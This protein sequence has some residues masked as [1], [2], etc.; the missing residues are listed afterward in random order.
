MRKL[1]SFFALALSIAGSLSAQQTTEYP[2]DQLKPAFH[3]ARRAAF[4]EK[5]GANTVG[6]FF[7]AQV[8]NRTN[9]VDF[10]YSQNK[11]FFYFTG[12]E[13]PNAVLFI[14]KDPQTILGKTG[15]EFLF[16][17]PRNPAMELWTGK[18]MGEQRAPQLLGIENVFNHTQFNA[19]ILPIANLDSVYS[20]Y[21]T[22]DILSRI[23]RNPDPLSKMTDIVDSLIT[24]SGKKL[25][26]NTAML[27]R[28]LRHRK[29]AEEL[30]L[31]Q[32]AVDI[33]CE[34]HNEV[35]RAAKPGMTEYQ[36]QAIME[37]GF[38]KSGSEYPGYPS[39]NGSAD[40]SCVLHYETNQRLMK[41][42][43]L[44]LSDCA[45]EYHGY[46]ADVTRTIPINGKFTPEQKIIYELVLEAADS[47]IAECRPGIP[48]RQPHMVANRVI[49][50][51]LVKLG[52]IKT[53]AEVRKYFPHGTSH[54]LGLDVHDWGLQ[55]LDEGVV[56]T[57]EPGIYIPSGSDCDK[58][59]WSIGV[60]IED[61]IVIT[62]DGRRNMSIASPR[63]VADVEKMM[64]Q[65]SR[66]D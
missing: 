30:V 23:K 21:R 19:S 5:M 53:E 6:I 15:N 33:S 7:A 44:L 59:W 38:K 64:K 13:E 49:A 50:R 58:K 36:A 8:R 16:V 27:M 54:H 32:K 22:E 1:L 42:G 18:I 43:D 31:I 9:D 51:G 46:T 39:I 52:I 65:K 66:F 48:F 60:R 37:W 20:L 25:A 2:T 12:F 56:L 34:A 11:N 24:S 10:Q 61:D 41:D 62:K 35:I 57:V 28:T 45:A 63:T 55:T 26:N 14:F 47:A 29:T 40:N 3:A 17:Q 4:R